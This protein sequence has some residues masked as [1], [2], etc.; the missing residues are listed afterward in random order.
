MP[1]SKRRKPK[2][3]LPPNAMTARE[4]D[5]H[6]RH[7]AQMDGTVYAVED[8]VVADAADGPAFTNAWVHANATGLTYAEGVAWRDDTGWVAHA[9]CLDTTATPPV[10]VEVTDGFDTATQYK[11]WAMDTEDV[12]TMNGGPDAPAPTRSLLARGLTRGGKHADLIKQL[13]KR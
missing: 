11:G 5:A 7:L 4:A 12:H 8:R 2:R 1:V 13:S 10:V 9:W 3:H 6:F